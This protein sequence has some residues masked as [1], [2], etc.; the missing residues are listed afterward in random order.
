MRNF[1]SDFNKMRRNHAIFSKFVFGFIAFVFVLMICWF[2]F[3]GVIAF[4]A[5]D[6]IGEVGISGTFEQ[7]W[8]GEKKDCKLPEILK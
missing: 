7:L 2:I 8:C 3:L 5:S 1:D 4:K 6:K